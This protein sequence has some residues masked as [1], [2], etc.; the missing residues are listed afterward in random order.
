M[1]SPKTCPTKDGKDFYTYDK[2]KNMCIHPS[3]QCSL[4]S[5]PIQYEGKTVATCYDKNGKTNPSADPANAGGG[6]TSG[7]G[8]SKPTLA[9]QCAVLM[10]FGDDSGSKPKIIMDIES[11]QKQEMNLLNQMKNDLGKS[12]SIKDQTKMNNLIAELKG[13]Q[14]AR[15]TLLRQLSYVSS[16]T[17]CTLS[18]DRTALQDQIS[19]LMVAEDQLKTLEK[20]TQEL[21][22]SRTNRHRMVEITNY[23]YN[24]FSSHAGIF[25]TI[26]FC[27][28]FILGGVYLNGLGWTMLGNTIIV[29]A[30]AVAIFLTIKRIWW[31]YYR[32]PMNWNQFEWTERTPGGQQPSVWE[33]DKA[34]FE[35]GYKQAK[36]EFKDLKKDAESGYDNAKKDINK[37]YGE[38]SQ[39]IKGV[40]KNI[41]KDLSTATSGLGNKKGVSVAESFAPFN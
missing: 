4:G 16:T 8:K 41:G 10:P 23:E 37:A 31:N 19:M 35:R 30:I 7:S 36:S 1:S 40:S 17:Q 25:K 9:S 24:R 2:E 29:L 27:S 5:A 20:Q 6:G 38:A 26:A 11:L 39:A 28:L 34:F 3:I 18:S 33:V 21:I 15:V 22:N 32:N 12:G 13:I 14:N